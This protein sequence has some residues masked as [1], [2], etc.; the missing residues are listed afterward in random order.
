MW[1]NY[2]KLATREAI[3]IYVK[4]ATLEAIVVHVCKHIFNEDNK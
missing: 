2:V 4:L 1:E 3:V